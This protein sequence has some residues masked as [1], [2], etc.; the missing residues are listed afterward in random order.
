[1]QPDPNIS[2][3]NP[4]PI[5]DVSVFL[6]HG[7]VRFF[8]IENAH[9]DFVPCIQGQPSAWH[10]S[11]HSTRR[12]PSPIFSSI[13][14]QHVPYRVCQKS[15][16]S[17]T[18]T[19]TLPNCPNCSL[20]SHNKTLPTLQ[21]LSTTSSMKPSSFLTNACT[22]VSFETLSIV[23]ASVVAFVTLC[24]IAGPCYPPHCSD[25][26]E[27]QP[28]KHLRDTQSGKHQTPGRGCLLAK[29]SQNRRAS[30]ESLPGPLASITHC[31]LSRSLPSLPRENPTAIIHQAS[32]FNLGKSCFYDPCH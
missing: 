13:T 16:V 18:H 9:K 31:Q 5:L 25:P 3:Y 11:F 7:L 1:M 15:V 2:P 10:P 21:S 23:W 28:N 14:F 29:G 30:Q 12:P 19:T 8:P 32:W 17:Q 6:K 27:Q 20:F 22:S 26:M 24:L 4:L